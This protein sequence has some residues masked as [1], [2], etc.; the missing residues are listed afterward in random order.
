MRYALLMVLA[1]LAAQASGATIVVG[2]DASALERLAAKELQKYLY[3]ATG[4]LL[5]ISG[6]AD[7]DAIAVGTPASNPLAARFKPDVSGLGDEGYL[8]RTI[9]DGKRRIVLVTGKKPQGVLYGA[10]ALLEEYG[11]GFYL[12]GDAVPTKSEFKLLDIDITR[13]PALKIRGT[14][15]WYNFFNSPTA[16]DFEDYAWF[17][18]NL[19]KTKNNFIGFHSYDAEPF[20]GYKEGDKYAWA[21]PVVSTA[22]ST[23]GTSPMKTGEFGGETSKYFHTDYF[24]SKPSLYRDDRERSIRDSQDLLAKALDYGKARGLKICVGFETGEADPTDPAAIDRLEKRLKHLVAQYPMLDHI[25]IWEPEAQGLRGRDPLPLDSDFGAYYRRYEPTFAY[26]KDPRRITEAVRMTIYAREAYRIIK[27]TAPHIRLVVSAWGGDHH[28]RFTDFYPGMDR[29]LPKDIIFSALDDI[30]VSPDV[31]EAYGKLSKGREYWPIPWFEFDGDQWHPQPNADNWLNACRDALRKGSQGI[32]G[33]HWRTRDVEESH[34]VMSQFA[35]DPSLTLDRF[36]ADYAA[37]CFGEDYVAAMAEIL[38][39]WQSLGY[40]LVGG[41]GQT[42]CGHFG[43]GSPTDPA[44]IERLEKTLARLRDIHEQ[45]IARP[46]YSRQ[47][48]RVAYMINTAEWALGYERTS[49]QLRPEGEVYQLLMKARQARQDGDKDGASRLAG[50][51]LR[52]LETC[53]FVSALDACARKVTNKGELGVLATVNTKAWAS[54]RAVQRELETDCGLQTADGIPSDN[55]DAESRTRTPLMSPINPN[56]VWT[57]GE[58]MPIKIV[59]H[60]DGCRVRVVYREIGKTGG[61]SVMLKGLAPRYFESTITPTGVGVEY[62]AELLDASGGMIER[63]PGKDLWHQVALIPPVTPAKAAAAPKLQAPTASNLAVKPGDGGS[64]VARWMGSVGRF[65]VRRAE[66]DGEF[67]LLKV[68]SDTWFEDRDVEAGKA[69]RY[70][71]T[72]VGPGG[73]GK[74]IVSQWIRAPEPDELA[75]PVVTPSAGPAK[76]RLRWDKAELGV[77]GFNVYRSAAQ[78]GPWETITGDQPVPANSWYGHLFVTP[79]EPGAQM[80]YKVVP[81]NRNGVEGRASEPV[82]CTAQ[83]KSEPGLVLSLDFDGKLPEGSW[84]GV[85]AY[86]PVNGAPA[87]HFRH[88]NHVVVPNRPEFSPRDEITLAMWVKLEDPGIMP[89]LLSHGLWGVQGYFVQIYGGQVRF[90]L[91]GVGTVD[92]GSVK[93]GEWHHIACT[94]DGYEMSVYLDGRQVGRLLGSGEVSQSAFN[95]YVG[96]YEY[97]GPDFETDCRMTGV[98]IYST[99]LTADEIKAEYDR[100]AGKLR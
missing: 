21:E 62:A 49:K 46:G 88:G 44:K 82:R 43:W 56:T 26:L 91:H 2:R 93:A 89:V 74:K 23:W 69:Y 94:Y 6:A 80:W 47:A 17:F 41:S 36:Y 65:E 19:V 13:K 20:A 33:I 35:W 22:V 90:Y 92:A 10:Y 32:L 38:M 53:D 67:A 24:G 7:G 76:V 11:F 87:A 95:L 60:Q 45:M 77:S 16:W 98:R 55:N 1:V 85:A 3:S 37:K 18:D 27:E 64:L 34:A 5:P 100:L 68:T 30:V 96:R 31:S 75:A 14:L 12:G 61:R 86:E 50:E 81:L 99:A 4:T 8:L 58:P 54:Y 71:I 28:L 79:A 52:K 72:P 66:D 9:R 39:E 15:P 78:S 25:W 97:P 63:W 84:G 42:E 40:R 51:A 57:A 70:S 59:A 29:L 83:T 48:E 73:T